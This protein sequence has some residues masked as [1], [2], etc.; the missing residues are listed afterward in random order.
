M[1]RVEASLPPADVGRRLRA[2]GL[3]LSKPHS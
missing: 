2:A 3:E 1:A